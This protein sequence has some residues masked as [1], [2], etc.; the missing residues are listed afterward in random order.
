[1]DD[2]SV[3]EWETKNEGVYSQMIRNAV[4]NRFRCDNLSPRYVL[5]HTLSHLLIRALAVNCGYQASSMKE[6]VYSTYADGQ[7]MAGLL[8][9][10]TAAY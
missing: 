8:I 1:M 6:R 3:R 2:D 7:P 10:T 4:A 5:L 9:Y